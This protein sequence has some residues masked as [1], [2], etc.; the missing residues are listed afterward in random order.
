MNFIRE[1]ETKYVL[2][3]YQSMTPKNLMEYLLKY[4]YD[5]DCVY[6]FNNL[7]KDL[8]KEVDDLAKE[9]VKANDEQIK[10]QDEQIKANDQ[11]LKQLDVMIEFM[12]QYNKQL[13][14]DIY[15]L[16]HQLENKRE[17]NRQL[18]IF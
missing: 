12:K 16:E 18:G 10:A 15:L 11:K 14:N 17:L 2:S 5:N 7:P 9:V 1:N 13:D 4:N 3:T 6:I 8:Q